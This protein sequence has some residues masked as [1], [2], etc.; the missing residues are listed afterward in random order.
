MP[1]PLGSL[2]GGLLVA[3]RGGRDSGQFAD[4]LVAGVDVAAALLLTERAVG[5]VVGGG[6]ADLVQAGGGGLVELEVG[7]GQVLPELLEAL[8][9]DD[10]CGHRRSVGEPA[11]SDLAGGRTDRRRDVADG[12]EGVPVLLFR[13]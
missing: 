2:P 3:G 12:V 11:E 13:S 5:I 1:V 9:P 4:D 6:C 10:G 7:T 8:G